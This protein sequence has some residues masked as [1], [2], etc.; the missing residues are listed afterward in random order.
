MSAW[1]RRRSN[2]TLAG[3]LGLLL[4]VAVGFGLGTALH[5][6]AKREFNVS[7]RK[8]AFTVEGQATPRIVVQLNDLVRITFRAEDIPHSFTI[9]DYKIAKRAEPGT[10][11]TFEFRADKASDSPF[12]F[13]CNLT[14]DDGCRKMRGELVVMSKR[15]P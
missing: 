9:D 15:V 14:I 10:P 13:Y 8:Y 4:S 5:A 11:V 2:S 12:V 1:T 3:G 7:A 6:Q